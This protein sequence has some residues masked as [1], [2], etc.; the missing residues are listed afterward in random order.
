MVRGF[1]IAPSD[2]ADR[3]DRDWPGGTATGSGDYCVTMILMFCTV[4]HMPN[5]TTCPNR[6]AFC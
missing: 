1:I 6:E 4:R 5:G 2:D 3:V